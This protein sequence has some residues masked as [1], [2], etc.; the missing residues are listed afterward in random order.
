LTDKPR[1]AELLTLGEAAKLTGLHRST[2]HGLIARGKLEALT[3]PANSGRQGKWR[4]VR[5]ADVEKLA[6][7]PRRKTAAPNPIER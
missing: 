1:P 2:L 7:K 3:L 5:R 6:V 4:Y